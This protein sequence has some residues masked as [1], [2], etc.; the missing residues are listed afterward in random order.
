M[1]PFQSIGPRFRAWKIQRQRKK[2]VR[3]MRG[4]FG[5]HVADIPDEQIEA[6]LGEV[7]TMM[8]SVLDSGKVSAAVAGAG[9][10]LAAAIIREESDETIALLEQRLQNAAWDR[11]ITPLPLI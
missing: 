10:E 2:L 4:L 6:H 11:R 5:S 3:E 7:A 8:R 9:I 1:K